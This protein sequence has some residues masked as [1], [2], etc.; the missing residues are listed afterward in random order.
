MFELA[1]HHKYGLSLK[2]PVMPASGA[3]GYGDEYADLVD[4][5]LLGAFVTNPV[6][7]RPRKTAGG[8]RLRVHSD[9]FVVHTGLPNPGGK[10][11][12]SKDSKI[13]E[14]LPVPV[15]VHLVATT[16]EETMKAAVRLSHLRCVAGIE[17]GLAD[18]LTPDQAVS[19]VHAAGEGDKP[20][21]VRIPFSRVDDL[22]PLLSE[23]GVSALTLTAPPRAVLP[24]AAGMEDADPRF[25]R[26]RLYGPAVLPLLL[27]TL[28]R[29]VSKLPVPIIACG[30]IQS[31]QEALACL[32][33]GATAVQ[34]DAVLWRNPTLL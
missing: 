5:S 7:L 19:L 4:F 8:P 9:H 23:E 26:G 27:G 24:P 3:M 34:I 1:P 18:R 17:L 15:I 21:I 25:Y 31:A 10:T 33:L 12:R 20:V 6:S 16:A 28:S 30:G 11:G 22:A 14:R 32:N 2:R 29:W 13:W